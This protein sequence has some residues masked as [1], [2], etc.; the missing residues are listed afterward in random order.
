MSKASTSATV[1]GTTITASGVSLNQL[2]A[3]IE[4]NFVYSPFRHV[5]F[6]AEVFGAIPITG[7]AS[8]DTGNG[9]SVNENISDVAVGLTM[10]V[11]GY[12]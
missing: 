9:A 1:G 5:G 10:G 2:A 6:D 11:L 8:V 7:S 3:N 4:S 12:F